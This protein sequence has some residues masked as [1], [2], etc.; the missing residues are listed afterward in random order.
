MTNKTTKS[1]VA[2]RR[3]QLDKKQEQQNRTIRLVAGIVGV[4]ALIVIGL[5]VWQAIAQNRAE[6]TET[7]TDTEAGAAQSGDMTLMEGERPAAELDPADR[8]NMYSEYP[9]MVIDPAKSYEAVVV[10]DK[11]DIRLRLFAEEAPQTVNNFVFLANQGFYDGV[12][13]HRVLEGFMA[14]GG[15]PSGTG[16]G[17]PG[18]EFADETDNDLTFDRAG[19]LAMANRGPATNGSQFFITYAPTEHLNGLHTIFGEVIEG[20]EVLNSLTRRDPTAANQPAADVIERIE[21]YESSQ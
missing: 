12:V 2:R 8:N 14:Q 10:T 17:G 6:K 21:I 13:F 3:D 16:S 19:L 15:D 4:V 20:M 18:Y 11:G 5:L 7:G 1:S 9:E